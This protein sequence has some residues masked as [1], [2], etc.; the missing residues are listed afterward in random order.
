MPD[1]QLPMIY[2]HDGSRI[3]PEVAG[4]VHGPRHSLLLTGGPGRGKTCQVHHA[5][6]EGTTRG[7]RPIIISDRELI[8]PDKADMALWGSAGFLGVDE[9]GKRSSAA[10]L[11]N[12]CDVIDVRIAANRKTI[13]VTNLSGAEV[14]AMDARLAS[15]LRAAALI[16][17]EGGDMRGAGLHI[18]EPGDGRGE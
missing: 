3:M 13:M 15:R 17:F 14:Q 5:A 7:L 10:T 4:W 16:R 1:Y 11:A 9:I 12:L 8:A 6:A 2:A 18:T